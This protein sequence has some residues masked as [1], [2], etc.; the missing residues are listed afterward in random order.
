M[1]AAPGSK[2]FP[3]VVSPFE[4]NAPTFSPDGQWLAYQSNE[5]GG[6][7]IYARR[8][9]G[10]S[11]R[12]QISPAGGVAPRWAANGDLFYWFGGKMFV[13]AA[14][15]KGETLEVGKPKELF[16]VGALPNYDVIADGQ[17]LLMLQP[18]AGTYPKDLVVVENWVP[19]QP[20]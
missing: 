4:D 20:R 11:T 7:E 8:I 2:S 3:F 14:R 18:G 15:P 1:P 13:I 5:S 10:D 17:Q 16:S 12:I 9:E 19:R 6:D